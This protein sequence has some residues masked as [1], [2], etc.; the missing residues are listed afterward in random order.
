MSFLQSDS[1]KVVLINC[2]FSKLPNTASPAH[3]HAHDATEA[4]QVQGTEIGLR[5]GGDVHKRRDVL[6]QGQ[7]VPPALDPRSVVGLQPAVLLF[8][9]LDLLHQRLVDGVSL[10]QTVDLILKR[11]IHIQWC[12]L[13]G[14]ISQLM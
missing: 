8:Q 1:L 10:N 2:L 7:G 14:K 9:P 5:R 6:S 11:H 4:P 12:L 13:R 3:A